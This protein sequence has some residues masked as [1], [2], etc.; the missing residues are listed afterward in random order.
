MSNLS[1]KPPSPDRWRGPNLDATLAGN[2]PC[3]SCGKNL[4]ACGV[5]QFDGVTQLVC[6]ACHSD[7]LR[8]EQHRASAIP[9]EVLS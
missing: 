4:R 9:A 7:V 2:V 5:T 6:M 8:V 3:P 1:N